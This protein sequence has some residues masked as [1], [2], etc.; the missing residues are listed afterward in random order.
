VKLL[1]SNALVILPIVL[2]LLFPGTLQFLAGTTATLILAM[3]CRN[4]LS[5]L[6]IKHEPTETGF[7]IRFLVR[8]GSN[9]QYSSLAFASRKVILAMVFTGDN[10]ILLVLIR[11]AF[12][13]EG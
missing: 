4:S 6:V 10:K 13:R 12:R 11:I 1:S 3:F 7:Q 2:F 5:L 8:F 9:F